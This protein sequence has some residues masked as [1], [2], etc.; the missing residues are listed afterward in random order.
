MN[1]KAFRR[2]FLEGASL[3]PLRRWISR[4]FRHCDGPVYFGDQGIE[5]CESCGDCICCKHDFVNHDRAPRRCLWLTE[6]CAF[7]H[8]KNFPGHVCEERP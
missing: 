6:G 3:R 8:N 2:G 1:W 7:A 4:R 5:V